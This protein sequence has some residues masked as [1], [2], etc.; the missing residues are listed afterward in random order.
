MRFRRRPAGVE[1][2]PAVRH[3][4]EGRCSP[5]VRRR[6]TPVGE[7]AQRALKVLPGDAAPR[8]CRCTYCECTIGTGRS[9]RGLL[10]TILETVVT[11]GGTTRSVCFPAGSLRTRRAPSVLRRCPDATRRLPTARS[12]QALRAVLRARVPRFA[13]RPPRAPDRFRSSSSHSRCPGR[14]GRRYRTA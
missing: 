11:V 3:R 9:V 5:P 7:D 4:R 6:R 10:R 8:C 13:V 1:P 2:A 14:R 12:L